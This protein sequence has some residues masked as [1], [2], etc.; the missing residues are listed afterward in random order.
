MHT[1]IHDRADLDEA[2]SLISRF[3]EH[4]ASEAAARADKSRDL[5]NIIH[6]CR[7]RM[8]GRMILMLD[9][10]AAPGTVH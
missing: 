8:I 10:K 9:A 5:G 4:A 3:G 1:H 6:F 2:H 7:W